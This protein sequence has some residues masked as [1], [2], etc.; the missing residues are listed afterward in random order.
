MRLTEPAA[1][2]KSELLK[3]QYV[4]VMVDPEKSPFFRANHPIHLA[5]FTRFA[6]SSLKMRL[7]SLGAGVQDLVV[8]RCYPIRQA[9]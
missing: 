8:L 5:H 4:G 6:R 7:A 3:P 1:V 2:F 9:D